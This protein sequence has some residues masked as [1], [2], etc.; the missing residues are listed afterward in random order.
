MNIHLWHLCL[1]I[2]FIGLTPGVSNTFIST[3]AYTVKPELTTEPVYNAHKYEV[4][5]DTFITE[6]TSEQRPSV[7]N[8][9]YFWVPIVNVVYRFDCT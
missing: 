3:L 2:Y 1:T 8:E 5:I 7:N 9:H 4:P 6:I